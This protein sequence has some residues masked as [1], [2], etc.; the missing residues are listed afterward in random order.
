MYEY[1]AVV[2]RTQITMT[3]AG[4]KVTEIDP[5]HDGDTLWLR[6]DLGFDIHHDMSIRL[7]GLDAPELST[8]AGKDVRAWLAAALP[9][10]TVVILRTEKD[11]TEKYGRYLGTIIKPG[12]LGVDP[13][14]INEALLASGQAKPYDGGKRIGAGGNA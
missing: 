4:P 2:V 13:V 7:N 10:G 3:P 11:H 1:Q 6:V 8:Q 5:V 9:V 12:G 14:N